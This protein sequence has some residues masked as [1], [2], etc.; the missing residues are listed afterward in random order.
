MGMQ[1]TPLL[2]SCLLDRGAVAMRGFAGACVV[3][4]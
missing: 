3:V 2:M 1:R 4:R